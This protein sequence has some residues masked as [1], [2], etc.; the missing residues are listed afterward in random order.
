MLNVIIYKYRHRDHT[1]EYS[2]RSPLST[3][4]RNALQEYDGV[5][6]VSLVLLEKL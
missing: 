4:I 6:T 1:A 3:A 5:G 2:I